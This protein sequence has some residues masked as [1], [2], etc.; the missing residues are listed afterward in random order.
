ML[1]INKSQNVLFLKS[2]EEVLKIY[3]VSTGKNN[4]TPVGTFKIASKIENPVWFKNGGPPFP[5]KALRMN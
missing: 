1:L 2:G 3:H 5:P 4:I